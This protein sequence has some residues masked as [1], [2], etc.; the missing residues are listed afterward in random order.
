MWLDGS[1]PICPVAW[2]AELSAMAPAFHPVPREA[3]GATLDGAS[4]APGPRRS[5][6]CSTKRRPWRVSRCSTDRGHLDA[7]RAP[8]TSP[9]GEG[10][11]ESAEGT[12][13]APALS[14][15]APMRW[16]LGTHPPAQQ[17]GTGA[18]REERPSPWD[19]E[20]SEP[21]TREAQRT[22]PGWV[23]AAGRPWGGGAKAPLPR[24]PR[25]RRTAP[26]REPA[27]PSQPHAP[28]P[29]RGIAPPPHL[30]PGSWRAHS[31]RSWQEGRCVGRSRRPNVT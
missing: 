22:S 11:Q 10:E 15:A 26:P 9:Q 6:M 12:A 4:R 19:P 20:R 13:R 21:A 24:W 28:H 2:H 5:V 8:G 29:G 30:R 1:R 23:P 7:P 18:S 17:V 25:P 14:R 27:R 31:V 16:G 3:S